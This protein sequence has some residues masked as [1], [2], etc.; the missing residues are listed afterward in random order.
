MNEYIFNLINGIY[1]KN[2][3]LDF[4]GVFFAEYLIFLLIAVT[5]IYLAVNKS[6]LKDYFVIFGPSAAAWILSQFIKLFNIAARPLNPEASSFPSG[7]TSV[8]F[9][10][11]FSFLFFIYKKNKSPLN[12][13]AAA[14]IIIVA[15]L[16][17]VSRIF[18]AKHWPLDIMGGIALG[19]IVPYL[20]YQYK[21]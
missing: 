4:I 20:L 18:T 2:A 19:F 10:I 21:K 3:V 7:H 8:A 16:I 9:A 13:A 5:F 6:G 14:I 17:G 1:G 12:K 11:A 15:A